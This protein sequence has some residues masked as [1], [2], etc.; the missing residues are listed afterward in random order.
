MSGKN[1]DVKTETVTYE[2]AN[3]RLDRWVKRRMTLSQGEVEKLLRKGQIRVDGARAK[4]NTRVQ[5]GQEVRLPPQFVVKSTLPYKDEFPGGKH[6]GG[7]QKFMQDMVLFENDEMFVLNKPQG[8]AVQGGTNT[9]RHV[10]GMLGYL[11]GSN[12]HRPKLVHRL[13]KAT[14]GVL[15]VAKHP[16]SAARLGELFRGRTLDK[17]YWAVTVK[18]PHPPAGQVRCWVARGNGSEEMPDKEKMYRANQ[19]RDFSK[20]AISDYAVIT[21]AG[22]QAAWVALKPVTGRTHQLRLHMFELDSSILGDDKYATRREVPQGVAPGLHL[23]ARS[24]TIPQS[25]GKPITVTA[26]LPMHMKE[27]FDTL[28]FIESE[29]GKDPMEPFA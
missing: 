16:A 14:S 22:R 4:S 8:F 15:V 18:V 13:D 2:E 27:T 5:A 10:D 17:V 1:K 6:V 28:G 20:H 23:H 9:Y 24:I 25:R 21:T 29:A 11:R 3:T 12:E 26:P 7:D 19:G